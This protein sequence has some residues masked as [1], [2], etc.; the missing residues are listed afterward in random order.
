[1]RCRQK[2]SERELFTDKEIRKK[3]ISIDEN[4]AAYY[5]CYTG[6]KWGDMLNYNLCINTSHTEIGDIASSLA[7]MLCLTE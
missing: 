4:R 7:K 3:I 1:M 2:A 6:Q 5:N